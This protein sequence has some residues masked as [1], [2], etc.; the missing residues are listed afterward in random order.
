VELDLELTVSFLALM[1][2]E[3]FGRAA[4]L[5]HIA[6]STLTK[7]IQRLEQQL[8]VDLLER[9]PTGPLGATPAGARFV[10]AARSLVDHAAEVVRIARIEE[11]RE[12]LRIGVPAGTGEFLDFVRIRDLTQCIRDEHPATRFTAVNVPFPALRTCLGAEKVDLLLTIGPVRAVGIESV[13]IPVTANRIGVV[14]RRHRLAGA[15][16][17]DVEQFAGEPIIYNPAVP[18]EFMNHFWL[19]DVRPRSEA[20]LISIGA[21]HADAAVREVID[22]NVMVSL[23]RISG[24]LVDRPVRVPLV[25]A[26]PVRFYVARRRND[27]SYLMNS[28]CSAL[29]TMD[30]IT[31]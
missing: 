20:R 10:E 21:A 9:C 18:D 31:L 17:I 15:M 22:L 19:G 2:T 14:D 24:R 1:D 12:S 23:D 27:R 26:T 8:G 25:G 28:L 29:V 4:S 6:P 11:H 13:P 7:R 16:E 3:N 30:P 5:L